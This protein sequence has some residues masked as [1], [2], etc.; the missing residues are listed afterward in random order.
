MRGKQTC[1][2]FFTLNRISERRR[3]TK[4]FEKINKRLKM[5]L[6]TLSLLVG[7][8]VSAWSSASSSP[9][10]SSSSAT[11]SSAEWFS[12]KSCVINY[13]CMICSVDC[14]N[15]CM[16][17]VISC[18]YIGRWPTKRRISW[19]IQVI[20]THG[21]RGPIWPSVFISHI[22]LTWSMP[23]PPNSP[24]DPRVPWHPKR[25]TFSS[26]KHTRAPRTRNNKSS[27]SSWSVAS[28]NFLFY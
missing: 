2:P 10:S 28:L 27:T 14:V 8:L 16:R 6:I 20:V 19:K 22:G 11:A 13:A 21:L 1:L 23:P 3:K 12:L 18:S 5:S 4:W 15:V 25:I 17:C 9:L 26:H 7:L 24:E